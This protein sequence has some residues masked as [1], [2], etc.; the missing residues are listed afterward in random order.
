[1]SKLDE[2]WDRWCISRERPNACGVDETLILRDIPWLIKRLE[3]FCNIGEKVI[4][5]DNC[6]EFVE[7][8][9]LIQKIRGN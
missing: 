6:E 9:K 4:E 8:Q 3:E 1:M 2:I 7:I 5:K